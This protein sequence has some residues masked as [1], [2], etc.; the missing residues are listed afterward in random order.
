[1]IGILPAN[2]SSEVSIDDLFT[3]D[4]VIQTQNDKKFDQIV[5][6]FEGPYHY[7]KDQY[8]MLGNEDNSFVNFNNLIRTKDSIL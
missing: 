1:M 2:V 3:A 8:H 5:L 4:H 6:E 7:I